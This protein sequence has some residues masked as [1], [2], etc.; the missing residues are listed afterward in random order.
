MINSA[1][2]EVLIL[3]EH[4][5]ESLLDMRECIDAMEDAL[6]DLARGG[7][8]NPLRSVVR[9]PGAPG[10]LGL[11]AAWRAGGRGGGGLKE[12]CVYPDNPKRGLDTHVGAVLLHDG[13]TGELIGVFNASAITAIR[14]AAVSAVA[15]KLLAR[16]DAK[17]LAIAGRAG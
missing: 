9:A 2:S 14:T 15:T 11:M 13:D 16:E 10:L 5:V 1:M 12:V 7:V 3:S 8:H 6:R 17:A 4:E